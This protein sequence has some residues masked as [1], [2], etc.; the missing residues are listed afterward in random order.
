MWSW[1]FRDPVDRAIQIS[2]EGFAAFRLGQSVRRALE[3][4]YRAMQQEALRQAVL[5]ASGLLKGM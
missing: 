4:E 5:D 2:S 1:P 3:A